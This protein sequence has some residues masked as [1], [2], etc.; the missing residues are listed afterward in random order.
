MTIFACQAQKCD[1]QRLESVLEFFRTGTGNALLPVTCEE[2][3][4]NPG[5][6]RF[7]SRKRLL[8]RKRRRRRLYAGLGLFN[9]ATHRVS[10]ESPPTLPRPPPANSL[11]PLEGQMGV[12]VEHV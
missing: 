9:V 1:A 12:F 2:G 10:V 8:V 5:P 11:I 7:Q 4:G 3:V 6:V